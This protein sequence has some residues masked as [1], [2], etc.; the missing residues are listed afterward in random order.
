MPPREREE[1]VKQ[2]QDLLEK[3]LIR[4]SSSGWGSAAV[5]VI[6]PDG[7]LRLCVE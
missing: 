5:F 2:T 6:K 7:S 3:D 4:P 1:L